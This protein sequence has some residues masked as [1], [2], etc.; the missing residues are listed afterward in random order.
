MP[1]SKVEDR[2]RGAHSK[3]RLDEKGSGARFEKNCDRDRGPPREL[4]RWVRDLFPKKVGEGEERIRMDSRLRVQKELGESQSGKTAFGQEGRRG[5]ETII[6]TRRNSFNG[7]W[8]GRKK[9]DVVKKGRDEKNG[10]Q[11]PRGCNT[12]FSGT[13]AHKHLC[14][15]GGENCKRWV[16]LAIAGNKGLICSGS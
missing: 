3:E 12:R 6:L 5:P 9:K 2:C 4:S 15:R 16:G 1:E 13:G 14:P 7:W 8:T 11:R 10:S